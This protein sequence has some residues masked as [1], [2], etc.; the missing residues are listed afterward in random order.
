MKPDKS[1]LIALL[2]VCFFWGTTYLAM[3]V[4]VT[5]CPPFLFSG[6]RM[7]GASVILGVYLCINKPAIK[8]TARMIGL[9]SLAGVLFFCLG[10][11][12][13]GWAE[14]QVPSGLAALICSLP[15]VWLVLI[16]VFIYRIE[17]L[18]ALIVL[19]VLLGLGG[20][21]LVFHEHVMDLLRP[22]YRKAVAV[23][24]LGNFS[25]VIATLIVK[26]GKPSE[27]PI[28]NACLQML[29][30]GLALMLL[31]L[32]FEQG[33]PV[34]WGRDVVIALV[35]LIVFGSVIAFAAYSYAL[36]KLPVTL[37]SLHTYANVFVAIAFGALILHEQLN[38]AIGIAVLVS[39]A[40]IYLVNR[41]LK[42]NRL[43]EELQVSL[44]LPVE[45]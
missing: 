38:A 31:H 26:K 45:N 36:A 17:K 25:W 14:K 5:T 16:N 9:N 42:I 11:G 12:M 34:T 30:G 40:G 24:V 10:V 43:R 32:S 39:M 20:M 22:E 44:K 4:G 35:Y 29:S 33:Q 28:F 1:A 7:L 8:V 13:V 27:F 15:P 2:L 23:T 18:N 37:V 21:V 19:G 6:I 41:G 3:R